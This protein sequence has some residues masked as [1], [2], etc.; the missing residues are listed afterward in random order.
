MPANLGT[1]ALIGARPVPTQPPM[2]PVGTGPLSSAPTPVSSSPFVEMNPANLLLRSILRIE[3]DGSLRMSAPVPEGAVVHLMTGDPDA[4]LTAAREAVEQALNALGSA[5]PLLAIAFV[6]AAWQSLFATRPTQVTDTIKTA[7]S[8]LPLV[9][10]YTFG[11]LVRL[12]LDE[13]PVLHNQ[14]IA[15][16]VF[17][18]ATE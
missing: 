11:Q 6:D 9:G 12:R 1:G 8:G 2:N 10:A 18:E 5:R 4:C 17:G 13:P 16:V 7:L 14:N 3:V 15:V